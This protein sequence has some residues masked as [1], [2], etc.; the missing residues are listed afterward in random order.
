[1][2][3]TNDFDTLNAIMKEAYADRVKDLIPDGVKLLN[4]I[5]FQSAEKQPG[6]QYIQPV[7]L[8]LEHGRLC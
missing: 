3:T 6:N 8:S 5:D 2:A 1:M 4:M 7:S